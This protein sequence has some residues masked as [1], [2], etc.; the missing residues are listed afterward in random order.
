MG[1]RGIA[2]LV[3]VCGVSAVQRLQLEAGQPEAK[4]RE[5]SGRCWKYIRVPGVS[6]W[7]ENYR[8]DHPGVQIN[9]QSIGSGGI[10]N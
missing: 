4:Q 1:N 3:S 5:R 10:S 9:Y 7:I 6:R 2:G 8:R